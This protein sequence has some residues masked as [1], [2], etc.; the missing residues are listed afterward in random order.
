MLGVSR[1]RPVTIKDVVGLMNRC[2]GWIWYIVLSRMHLLVGLACR[3]LQRDVARTI[4]LR[5][6]SRAIHSML[7][8]AKRKL[9]I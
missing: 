6:S 3:D 4:K 7:V 5:R 2:K 9:D 8:I 1:M